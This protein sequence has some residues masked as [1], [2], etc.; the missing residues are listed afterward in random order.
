M[1]N[2]ITTFIPTSALPSHPDTS[3][4]E[5]VIESVR[6][7]LPGTKIV[8]SCDGIRPSVEHRREAYKEYKNRLFE[9]ALK[10]SFQITSYEEHT[11]QVGMFIDCLEE[12][13]DTPLV[14]FLEHD[15][16][17][18]KKFIDWKAIADTLLYRDANIVRLYWQD[19]IHPEHVY[20]TQ[21]EIE[22]HGAN[23]LRTTQYSGWPNISRSEFY[24]DVLRRLNT[25]APKMLE[26]VCYGPWASSEW[27]KYKTLIY[28][29][30]DGANRFLHKNGRQGDPKEW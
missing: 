17:L 4:I 15:C 29:P 27:D 13:I 24:Q 2:V 9:V 14:L 20:L 19:V 7:Q 30:K 18:S 5:E 11:Q 10:E 22:F 25:G 23:F 26:D 21:G 28:Y 3:L 8:V 1:K 12:V 16:V 6:F